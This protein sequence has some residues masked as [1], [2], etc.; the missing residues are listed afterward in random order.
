[1]LAKCFCEH[2]FNNYFLYTVSVIAAQLGFVRR[3][4]RSRWWWDNIRNYWVWA[5]DDLLY[6]TSFYID[7]HL[8]LMNFWGNSTQIWI[9]SVLYV[10]IQLYVCPSISALNAREDFA[11]FSRKKRVNWPNGTVLVQVSSGHRTA[12]GIPT[13]FYSL[14]MLERICDGHSRPSVFFFF[15]LSHT[16]PRSRAPTPPS[17]SLLFSIWRNEWKTWVSLFSIENGENGEF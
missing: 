7:F 13:C 1:M 14:K 10:N 5:C 12:L 17:L 4:I 3:S 11:N 6:R 8:L 15:S 16:H 9:L 2:K